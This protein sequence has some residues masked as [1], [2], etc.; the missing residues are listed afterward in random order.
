MLI[1]MH[2]EALP[3]ANGKP[4]SV[5]NSFSEHT[6]FSVTQFCNKTSTAM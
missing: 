1:F 4:I 2:T 6:L 5:K 3:P